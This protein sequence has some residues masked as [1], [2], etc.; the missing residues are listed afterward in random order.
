MLPDLK[1]LSADEL[2]GW[3]GERGEPAFRA[4][5]IL[6]WVHRRGAR[7]FDEMTNV[8][9]ELR[10]ELGSSFSIGRPVVAR[11]VTSTD[12]TRKLL[13]TLADG[14]AVESV[15]IPMGRAEGEPRIT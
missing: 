7:S 9:R 5:Q 12:G 13:F 10:R 15:L 1:D 6:S 8:S 2:G 4:T 14:R 11:R 3:L